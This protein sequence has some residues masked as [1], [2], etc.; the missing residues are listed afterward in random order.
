MIYPL[1]GSAPPPNPDLPEE[2]ARCYTEASEILGISPRGAAALARLA[3]E[4]LFKHLERPGRGLNAQIKALVE[5]GIDP[6][7]QQMLDIVRV[8]G[9]NAVHPGQ[10]DLKDNREIA[11]TLLSL[12]NIIAENLITIPNQISDLYETA[13]PESARASIA[14]RDGR[15]DT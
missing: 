3:L 2:S 11:H 6:R 4:E 14:R 1:V 10:I 7:L 13:V 15:T 5:E 12:V 8:V 9:N